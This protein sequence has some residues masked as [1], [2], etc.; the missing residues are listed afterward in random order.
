MVNRNK[1]KSCR[2]NQ[3]LAIARW[4][5]N[6]EGWREGNYLGLISKKPYLQ[7][8]VGEEG[9]LWIVVSRA[10]PGDGRVYSLSFRLN[11]CRM[12]TYDQAT[13]FGK[14]AVMG[15]PSQS[16]VFASNDAK[17]LLLSLRF[18][19]YLPIKQPNLI[20]QSIQ[21]PRCLNKQDIKLLED[22]AVATDRWSVFISYQ[23]ADT[24]IAEQL[25][26]TLMQY[27]VNVFRDKDALRGGEQWWPA[28][29]HAIKRSRF[30]VVL[31]GEETHHSIWVRREIKVALENGIRVIPVLA[32][33]DLDNW[34]DH[35][36]L[37]KWHAL[38]LR[39][40]NWTLFMEQLLGAIGSPVSSLVE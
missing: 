35:P 17:L 14:Y 5:D 31:L 10:K 28:L 15:D 40:G 6:H 34:R 7:Q 2:E 26:G 13:T 22:Y 1:M 4:E 19:P 9:I 27:G 33:T 12:K 24:R 3:A 18:D 16:I 38:S 25:S 23:N 32:G 8:I 36:E 37:L 30:F 11:N 20:G 29:E 21:R 39:P